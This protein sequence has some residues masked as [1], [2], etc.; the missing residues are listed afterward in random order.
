MWIASRSTQTAKPEVL[1]SL[2]GLTL[3]DVE[4]LETLDG[5][6]GLNL[7]FPPAY[8]YETALLKI[9]AAM[10]L[11][12]KIGSTVSDAILLAGSSVT[13]KA[14]RTVRQTVK[15]KYDQDTWNTVA[16]PLQNILREKQRAALVS[17]VLTHPDLNQ[18]KTCC[19][20]ADVSAFFLI[21]VEQ[22]PCAFS[23]RIKQAIGS[24]QTF[25]QRCLLNLEIEVIA[26]T[27]VDD[28]WVEWESYLKSILLTVANREI[29]SY[30]ENY[31]ESP[32]RDDKTPFFKDL[33]NQ[34][35]Q[36]PVTKDTAEQTIMQY[37]DNL[38]VVAHL[39][40]LTCYHQK[41]GVSGAAT[42]I[43]IL[44]I[45]ARAQSVPFRYFYAKRLNDSTW[46]PW[47]KLNVSGTQ[48]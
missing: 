5:P 21:D 43:D 36:N 41:E 16:R 23:S 31:L 26:D 28:G 8:Q 15:S 40:V 19:T 13:D 3:W 32:F 10:S 44:H 14:A 47:E 39:H 7:A 6:T 2:A 30:P 37:L 1:T 48:R 20:P 33:E 45:F 35:L 24:V 17:D 29:L 27:E 9:A 25:V 11:V 22:G 12:R 4:A 18:R 38:D 42:A 34:L 46:T